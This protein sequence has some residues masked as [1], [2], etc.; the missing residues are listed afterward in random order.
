SGSVPPE[1][2][3][4]VIYLPAAATDSGELA[5]TVEPSLASGML[6]GLN[7]LAHYPYE[8]NEQTVSRFLPNLM[9]LR[10]FQELGISDP[11][12]ENQLA[13]QLGIAVQR[14]VSRQNPDG[15]WGY[16]PGGDSAPFISAYALWG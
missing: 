13:F 9:T 8:C 10:A 5:V 11:E 2:A 16:W 3:T 4:E 7:Y 14:L 1:G 15:G 6:E 12:L